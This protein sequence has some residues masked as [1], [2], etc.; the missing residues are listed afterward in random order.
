MSIA[1]CVHDT[2]ILYIIIIIPNPHGFVNLGVGILGVNFNFAGKNRRFVYQN[3][4]FYM[5]IGLSGLSV[6]SFLY[7]VNKRP[8]SVTHTYNTN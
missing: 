5:I 8:V 2:R 4:G 1:P 3:S 7:Y 6:A